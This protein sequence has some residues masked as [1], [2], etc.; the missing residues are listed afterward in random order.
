M[1]KPI[2]VQLYSLRDLAA[3]DFTN[4]LKTV[5]KIGYAGVE[6]AGLHNM[7]AAAVRKVI[8][9]EGLAVSSAHTAVFDPAQ[10]NKVEDEAK[11]LGYNKLVGG[12]W[13]PDL[14]F[15]D[16]SGL[17]GDSILARPSTGSEVATCCCP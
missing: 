13:I 11:A 8:D 7:P 4:V 12:F 14:A 3:K 1:A 17:N 16:H 5:S 6:F 2:S 9:S 15:R 10:W